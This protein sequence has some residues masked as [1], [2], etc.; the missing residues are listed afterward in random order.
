MAALSLLLVALGA[1]LR[2]AVVDN[3]EGL[4][5]ATV[6]IVLMVAGA[7]GFLAALL[8]RPGIHTHSERVVSPD[9]RHVVEEHHSEI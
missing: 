7:V 2:F 1:I 6:G 9:G 8:R 4:D 3:V 5:L